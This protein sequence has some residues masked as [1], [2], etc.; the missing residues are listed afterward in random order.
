MCKGI[1]QTDTKDC[2]YHQEQ[3]HAVSANI[4]QEMFSFTALGY[5]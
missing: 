4:R 1:Q 3:L 2:N 5:F